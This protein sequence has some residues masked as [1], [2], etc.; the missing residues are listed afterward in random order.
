MET[1]EKTYIYCQLLFLK[2]KIK[3]HVNLA[4]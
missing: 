3:E 1:N 2:N 4:G